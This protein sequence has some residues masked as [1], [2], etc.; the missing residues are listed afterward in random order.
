MGVPTGI[1]SCIERASVVGG[2]LDV[3]VVAALGCTLVAAWV[4]SQSPSRAIVAHVHSVKPRVWCASHDGCHR[5]CVPQVNGV[6]GTEFRMRMP[7]EA[8]SWFK[9]LVNAQSQIHRGR[10]DDAV[11]SYT[12]VLD[13]FRLPD[14]AAYEIHLALG[15]VSV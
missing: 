4:G 13:G 10:L 11:A 7:D 9:Y 2:P 14:S 8:K 12:S 5:R 15:Q 6:A 1:W 3:A